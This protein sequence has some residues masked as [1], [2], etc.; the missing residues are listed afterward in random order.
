MS[1]VVAPLLLL[2]FYPFYRSLGATTSYEYIEARFGRHA[3]FAVAG[4]FCLARLGWLGVVIY[5]P[6]LALSVVLGLNLWTAILLMAVIATAYAALG[7]LS[8]VIWTDVFQFVLLVGGAIWVAISLMLSVPG[9]GS[10]IMRI[11]NQTHHLKFWEIRIDLF[12]MTGLGVAISYF[13]Q[14]LQDYGVD[15]V[16]VQRLLSI[17]S[18]RGLARAIFFNA[19]ADLF[20]VSLL[21]FLGLGMFAYFYTFPERLDEGISGDKILPFYVVHGLPNGASGLLIAAILAAAMSSLDSGVHSISTVIVN[22]FVRPLRHRTRTVYN[23]LKLSRTLILALGALALGTAAYAVRIGQIF[24]AS[25]AFLSLFGGP[26]LA[27]FLLGMLTR[28]AHFP[29]WLVSAIPTIGASVWLQN[30]TEIHFIYY[31]PFSF[32][33]SFT[34]GYLASCLIDSTTAKPEFTLWSR[35]RSVRRDHQDEL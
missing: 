11:A 27:L 23:D 15:Q 18:F 5:S 14:L 25:T 12:H 6:A 22:D 21:L 31:F 24:K 13:L 10:E 29:G 30:W 7:G 32:A 2:I 19:L 3:R 1:P 16:S 26:V 8:A 35:R 17:R 33:S 34:L 4:L 20:L 28:R 9:G